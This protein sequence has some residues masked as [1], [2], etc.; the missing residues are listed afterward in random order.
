MVTDFCNR[1]VAMGTKI[2]NEEM[3]RWLEEKKVKLTPA[4]DRVFKFSESKDAFDY[5][6]TGKHTGKIVITLD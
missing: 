5:L 2:D 6:W 4:L 1:G 3:N